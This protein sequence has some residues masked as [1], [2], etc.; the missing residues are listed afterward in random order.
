MQENNGYV[1][2]SKLKE[3]F[4]DQLS[5]ALD[6]LDSSQ[7]FARNAVRLN[8]DH[9]LAQGSFGDVMSGKLQANAE[10]LDCQVHVISGKRGCFL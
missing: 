8:I 2:D 5:L 3:N 10:N 4:R 6:D 7:K 1:P 9:I